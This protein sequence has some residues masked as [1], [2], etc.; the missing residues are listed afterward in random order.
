MQEHEAVDHRI[1]KARGGLVRK[2]L[3]RVENPV[4]IGHVGRIRR[5][6]RNLPCF[7]CVFP[8]CNLVTIG[9]GIFFSLRGRDHNIGIID[10]YLRNAGIVPQAIKGDC[11]RSRAG[12]GRVIG[13]NGKVLP[14]D[15]DNVPNGLF[16]ETIR[17]TQVPSV[18]LIQVIG[19]GPVIKL[20]ASLHLKLG[21]FLPDQS[22]TKRKGKVS[23]DGIFHP[24]NEVLTVNAL[25]GYRLFH[26]HRWQTIIF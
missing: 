1:Y 14:T 24:E 21:L 11:K 25:K 2:R 22:C 3:T 4:E 9:P 20:Y 7:R 18:F 19:R 10:I 13:V 23:G 5:E 16:P 12:I 17:V 8:D 6:N 15:T 26:R